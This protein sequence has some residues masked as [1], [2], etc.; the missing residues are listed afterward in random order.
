MAEVSGFVRTFI[1]LHEDNWK[2][3]PLSGPVGFFN[4]LQRLLKQKLIRG[5]QCK[6]YGNTGLCID[7]ILSESLSFLSHRSIHDVKSELVVFFRRRGWYVVS[8][9]H[10]IYFW[11]LNIP[12]SLFVPSM[13]DPPNSQR[14]IRDVQIARDQLRLRHTR[15][16]YINPELPL[17]ELIPFSHPVLCV[18]AL[19]PN[20]GMICDCL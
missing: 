8:Y 3:M 17:P 16:T 2:H 13:T 10:T 19:P 5:E 1:R 18:H 7:R 4:F 20:N 11:N 9:E 12:T 14:I 6:L 15:L